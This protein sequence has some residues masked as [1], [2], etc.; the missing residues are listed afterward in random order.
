MSISKDETDDRGGSGDGISG[1]L[2]SV[3]QKTLLAVNL[4]CELSD[5]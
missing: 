2:L 1:A 3:P 4:T 5:V